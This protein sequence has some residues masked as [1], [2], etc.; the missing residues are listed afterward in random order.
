M[1]WHPSVFSVNS[2]Q[3]ERALIFICE[4]T[5]QERLNEDRDV[6]HSGALG[7]GLASMI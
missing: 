1:L 5:P 2:G 3:L 7:F 4:S 6:G